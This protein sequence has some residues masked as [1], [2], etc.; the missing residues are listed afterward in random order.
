MIDL[1]VDYS[2]DS[3]GMYF[4]SML[5]VLMMVDGLVYM[6]KIRYIRGFITEKAGI[7]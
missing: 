7:G 1:K 4:G 3:E 2:D 5:S 6:V